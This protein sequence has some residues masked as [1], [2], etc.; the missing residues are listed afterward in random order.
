MHQIAVLT[1]SSDTGLH[2]LN[3]EGRLITAIEEAGLVVGDYKWLNGDFQRGGK[4][5][6][7]SFE[8]QTE[9]TSGKILANLRSAL[10]DYG[11]D[12]NI[13]PAENRRK[14]LLVADMDS[15]II[16]SESLNDLAALAGKGE[17]VAAITARSM[18]GELD[19]TGSLRE[20]VRML[21]GCPADLIQAIID[22]AV[23]SP[24]AA[25]LVATMR[26]HGAR[27]VLASGGF[28][29][30]TSVVAELLGFDAHFANTLLVEDGKITGGVG[31][32]VLDQD[33]KLNILDAEAGQL[34]LAHADCA[35]I[36]DG[37]NDR[38]MTGVAGLGVAYRGKPALK[39]ATP[40]WLDHT[41]LRG[42]LWLQGYGDDEIVSS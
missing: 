35:T 21:E 8:T 27:C 26:R 20:R 39:E 19:F 33:A 30:L 6:E 22:E 4:A 12:I 18:R 15:T 14:R 1:T 11:I 2:L 41:D 17:E 5:F 42:L 25:A 16:T 36:G 23:V 7:A 13:V 37:A 28:T 34:G 10:A 32:P 3:A 31:E 38:G 40:L 9:A 29:F 24:G